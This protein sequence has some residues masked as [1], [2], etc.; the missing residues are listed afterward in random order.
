MSNYWS[1]TILK[2]SASIDSDQL[3]QYQLPLG[4][5]QVDMNQLIGKKISLEFTKNI[6]CI[7]TGKK[8]K[9]TYNQGYSYESFLKKA[10][11]DICIVKPEL[12][13][14]EKGTCREPDWGLNHC[15]QPHIIYLSNASDLKVG[16][17]RLKQVPQRWIDQGATQ[18][19]PIAQVPNRHISGL[20]EVALSEEFKDKTNWRLMLQKKSENQ[21]L[22]EIKKMI[23][24]RY[25][26]LFDK[27]Q[28]LIL[29]DQEYNI[30]YPI[31]S[32]PTKINSLSFDKDPIIEGQ[33]LGIKGQYLM[34]DRGRVLN[35]RKHQGYEVQLRLVEGN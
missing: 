30:N 35:V 27:Y 23:V 7:D 31:N 11:C 3:V 28:A 15:Y 5:Q 18:A 21:N 14:F 33:L 22:I 20:I 17:T 19:M 9:K 10:A 8:I 26:N 12:C 24:Q 4:N 2:M 1:G 6:F 29:P 34:F 16:I 25:Q 32:Y 13:H